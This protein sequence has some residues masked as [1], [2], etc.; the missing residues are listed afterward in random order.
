MHARQARLAEGRRHFH[1][2]PIDLVI[3][4]DGA[5]DA[6]EASHEAAWT[7][8]Q[9]VLDEL[10][11]EL[12]VLRTPVVAARVACASG[13]APL[14][15]ADDCPLRGSIARAMWFACRPFAADTI[16]P[17]AAVAGAVAQDILEHYRRAGIERAWV[18]N[19][20]DIAWLFAS[21]RSPALRLG[22]FSDLAALD[23]A[24]LREAATPRGLRVD[25]RVAVDPAMAARGAAT[26]GWRGRSFS[27]GIADSVTVLARTAAQADAAATIVANAVDVDDPKIVRRPAITL[28]D[29]SDLGE[30]LVTVDVP[31]LAPERVDAALE[32]GLACARRLLDA[33]LILQ[34]TLVCQRRMRH[35]DTRAG[36]RRAIAA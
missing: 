29:D 20:G 8:F 15:R 19:G 35:V 17:M 10:V 22:L 14:Q 36:A 18:N 31:P 9:Q 1:H 26:S 28:K 11:G 4:A 16:T 25:G 30:R 6:L 34:C 7:R 2:G 24:R 33:G 23:E 21:P 13:A 12:R 32:A 5:D 3:G 27:L